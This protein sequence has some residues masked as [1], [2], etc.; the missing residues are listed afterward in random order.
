MKID[1]L[2]IKVMEA[3]RPK[4][5][6]F[7]PRTRMH[8][9]PKGETVLDNLFNRHDRPVPEFR[10]L[11][12]Q[13]V[14]Q[15]PPLDP[16]FGTERRLESHRWSQRAGCSCGCSPGFILYGPGFYGYDVFVD[17]AMDFPKFPV[18][19]QEPT[20]LAAGI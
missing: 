1:I 5:R 4:R 14:A 18:P 2:E 16:K 11:V 15:L 12:E 10:A 8:F 20:Y 3:E 9:F 6:P 17:V 7:M 13:V 19:V